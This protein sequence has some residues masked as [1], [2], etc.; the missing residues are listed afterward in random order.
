MKKLSGIIFASVICLAACGNNS[1]TIPSTIN[2]T[3]ES[4]S[5]SE[6]KTS[7]TQ[8]S[9]TSSQ[10]QTAETSIDTETF[11]EE[12][13]A[14]LEETSL[15]ELETSS[16]EQ[17]TS[18]EE[19]QSSAEETSA[20]NP[21]SKEPEETTT[22]I[23]LSGFTFSAQNGV[24][25]GMHQD[26]KS[27]LNQLGEPKSYLETPSCAFPDSIDKIYTYPN[28]TLTTYTKNGNDYIYDIYFDS[29]NSTT[30]EGISIGSSLDKIKEIYGENYTEEFGL[31]TYTKD[32]MRLMFLTEDNIVTS[33]EY[34]G[35]S[36]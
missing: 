33:I 35:L 28:F 2:S 31:Y 10:E 32:G 14:S 5:V 34:S 26:I 4:Q 1:T 12:L 3:T 18:Y 20:T 11:S 24:Q 6:E 8:I 19:L 7:E 36:K 22:A 29:G 25:I 23:S 15:Q 21:L 27:I 13:T 30:K 9:E 17:T 16:Q